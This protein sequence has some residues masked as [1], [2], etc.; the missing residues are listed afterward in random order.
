MNR[1]A[2]LVLASL[3]CTVFVMPTSAVADDVPSQPAAVETTPPRGELPLRVGDTGPF[4]TLLH[5]RLS[6]LGYR[7]TADER[8]NSRFGDSTIA[9][10]DAVAEKFGLR[11]FDEV[12]QPLWDAIRVRAGDVGALPKACTDVPKAICL[13]TTQRLLRLVRD[14]DVVLTTDARF[15]IPGERT[16][17]GTFS[18]QHRS[19]EHF[20]RLYRTSM[21]LALFFSGGQAI[22]YS[23]FFARDGYAGGSHGC[24]NLRDRAVAQR[25]YDWAPRGTRVHIT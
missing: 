20:S 3:T 21:P 6:W 2:G 13:D 5:E 22:H 14:G 24:V 19:P 25:V 12:D 7:I 16:R 17:L 11:W 8:A 15:G 4:L 1:I 9:A 18:V 23:A 10:L